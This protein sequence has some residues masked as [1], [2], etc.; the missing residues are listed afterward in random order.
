MPMEMNRGHFPTSNGSQLY[1]ETPI[2]ISTT[3][4][5]TLCLRHKKK[6][7]NRWITPGSFPTTIDRYLH[8]CQI[9]E[10]HNVN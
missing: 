6:K 9:S 1:Q 5:C 8:D 10:S 3:P 4:S 7:K 2:G